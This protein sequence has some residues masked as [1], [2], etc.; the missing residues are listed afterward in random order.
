[1]ITNKVEAFKEDLYAGAFK[2]GLVNDTYTYEHMRVRMEAY[3]SWK[4]LP[5]EALQ[6]ARMWLVVSSE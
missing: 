3:Q 6:Q 1:M 4:E 2:Q 5:E